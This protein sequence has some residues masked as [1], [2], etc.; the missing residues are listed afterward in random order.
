MSS[1]VAPGREMRAPTT[2]MRGAR[3]RS[4]CAAGCALVREW[5]RRHRSRRELASWSHDER[6]DFGFAAE[7]DAEITKPFWKK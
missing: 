3:L 2:S 7:I 1:A 6:R 4:L 5:Q